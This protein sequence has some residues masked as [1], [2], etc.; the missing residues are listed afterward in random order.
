MSKS[1]VY[2]ISHGL[3]ARGLFQTDLLGRLRVAGIP[4]AVITKSMDENILEYCSKYGI[5]VYQY[6]YPNYWWTYDYQAARKYFLEDIKGNPVLWEKHLRWIRDN[7]SRSI[8]RKVSPYLYYWINRACLKFPYLI[9]LFK[10]NEARLLR[11]DEASKLLEKISPSM[12]VSTR[13]V[14]FMEAAILQAAKD[15]KVPVVQSILSWDNITSKGVFPV[16]GNYYLT[17]GSIMTEEVIQYYQAPREIIFEC[18]V[19]H[20][21]VHYST[22]LSPKTAYFLEKAGLNGN[23]PYLFFAMSSPHFAPAEIE[24]VEWLANRL[25]NNHYG[26]D[27]QLVVR[28][29]IQNVMGYM[30]DLTW[31]PRLKSLA[32]DRIAIDIPDLEE[33]EMMWNM[34]R[35]DMEKLSNWLVGCKICLNTASTVSIEGLLTGKPV[36]MALFDANRK[37]VPYY[38]SAKRLGNYIHMRK[39]LDLGGASI[40]ED[41]DSLDKLVIGFLNN[42]ESN[43]ELRNFAVTKEIVACDGK[44]TERILKALANL[45]AQFVG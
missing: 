39:F 33:S 41:F 9:R 36:I 32:N 44:S 22:A 2:L 13:P 19:P 24:I 16:T 17:W 6:N 18:G 26:E 42:P 8:W 15:S 40:A 27:M 23:K 21:D 30:A 35:D 5:S 28:P 43:K 4:V 12:V 3:T 29:H 1:V 14:E 20:F 31:L 45:Q 7:K 10:N 38:K 11:D 34:K 25:N 37:N